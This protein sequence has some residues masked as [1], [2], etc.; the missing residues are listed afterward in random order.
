MKISILENCNKF[1]FII[2]FFLKIKKPV[3]HEFVLRLI[4]FEGVV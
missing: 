1:L 2:L 3:S 4:K